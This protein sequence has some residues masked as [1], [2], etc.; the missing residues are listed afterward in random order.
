MVRF[1]IVLIVSIF[2]IS[3]F[4]QDTTLQ[5][6]WF[7]K[8]NLN[9]YTQVRYNRLLETNSQLKNEQGDKSWGENGGFLIRRIRLV[10]SGQI[11]ERVFFKFEP[12]F[13]TNGSSTNLNFGQVRDAYFDLGID[14]KNEF[15]LRIGQSKLPY[16]FEN[17]QSS[18]DR[19][20]L[21]RADAMNSAFVN[22]RDLGVMFYW[23]PTKIRQLYASLTKDGLKGSGD[24]GVVGL[25]VFNGQ[26]SNKPEQNNQPHVVA[27]A[28]YPFKINNQIIEISLQAHKGNYV[29]T[30]DQISDT[31]VRVNKNN[32][33]LDER[34]GAS[35]ILY[36]K[37][38]GI[39][40][41]Y[42]IGKGPEYNKYNNTVE[43]KNLHGGYVLTSYKTNIGRQVLIPFARYHYYKGGKKQETDARSYQVSEFNFGLEWQM[44]TNIE[45]TVGYTI[46]S[47]R[48]E[49]SVLRNNLQK[50]N[51][52]HLQAQL[53][54]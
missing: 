43:V 24:Y 38:F 48:F 52:L 13:A 34:I 33:Y 7:E 46:S 1:Y 4:A 26:A 8:I 14:A 28:S 54:F 30:K 42:N 12:D 22:E 16:G 47:R 32:S 41:E 20:I 45:F 25:G 10:F 2:S 11:N 17:M 49:D 50:G 6:P 23:A 39:Q 21:D 35:F 9:G 37:P 53:N 3:V 40:A 31:S 36:P 15:R 29:V 18:R 51:L 5:K 27:R 19:L 44:N